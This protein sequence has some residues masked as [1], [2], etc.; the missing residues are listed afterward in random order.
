M[1]NNE[2]NFLLKKVSA[3]KYWVEEGTSTPV[4]LF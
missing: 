2:T 1:I 3:S 4:E